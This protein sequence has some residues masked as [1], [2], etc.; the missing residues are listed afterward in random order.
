MTTDVFTRVELQRAG[1]VFALAL[2]A[3]PVLAER[4][5]ER[6]RETT[7]THSQPLSH[8]QRISFW[9]Q[10]VRVSVDDDT[11]SVDQPSSA[12]DAMH[13][14]Y[15]LTRG[16]RLRLLLSLIAQLDNDAAAQVM[17]VSEKAAQLSLEDAYR[18]LQRHGIDDFVLDR[19]KAQL[20]ARVAQADQH[21]TVIEGSDGLA[22]SSG[23][24]LWLFIGTLLA[25]GLVYVLSVA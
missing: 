1:A 22:A 20:L 24:S 15:L 2:R 19:W 23:L 12:S 9:Q 10:M 18:Q 13:P 17:H 6:V 21:D 11:G 4:A 3:D 8:E 14:L 5:L 7:G 16:P 25:L